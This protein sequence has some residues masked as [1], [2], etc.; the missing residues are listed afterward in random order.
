QQDG[1]QIAYKILEP[2]NPKNIENEIPLILII[3]LWSVKEEF[4]GL[5]EV[6]IFD[7]RGIGESSV[8]SSDDPISLYLMAKDTIALIKHLGIKHFNLFGWSMGGLIA[9]NVALNVPSDLNLEKLV[10]C[11]TSIQP[12]PPS[13]FYHILYDLPKPPDP[14][15][16]VQEQKD[17]IMRAFEK[18]FT[19]YMLEHPEILD[20]LAEI[21]F[22]SHRP[23]EI[24]KRQWEAIKGI[25]LI[26]K[27]Q[28]IE[29]PTLLLHGDSDEILPITEAEL[30]A[31]KIPNIKFIKLSNAGHM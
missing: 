24:F 26:S 18:C 23:F 2:S 1:S 15:K 11:S 6:I 16:N 20:K 27:V 31:S 9:L 22:N 5:E 10:I 8:A 7:N 3:G 14:L 29:T 12:P 19:D 25:D 28:T 21:Q 13:A 30:I 17:E 4:I